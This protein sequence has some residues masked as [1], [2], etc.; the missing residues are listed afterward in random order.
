MPHRLSQET[1]LAIEL[2]AA[3]ENGQ[4]VP[5]FQPQ[6]CTD[7]GR[8][9][10][11]EALARWEHPDNGL[12]SADAFVSLIWEHGLTDRFNEVILYQSLRALQQWTKAGFHVPTVAVNFSASDLANPKIVDK[13]KWELDRFE[14]EPGR[15][16]VEILEN[17]LTSS[18]NHTIS[19]NISALHDLGCRIDLDDFGT[20]HASLAS[21]RRFSVNRIKIDRSFVSRCDLDR[22][23]QNMLAA[24]LTMAEHLNVETLAEG[25]ES[26]GEHAMLAQL[27]C[28]H[29]QG[30]SI[31]R[32][33]PSH[34]CIDWMET[35]RRKQA[36]TPQIGKRAG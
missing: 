36:Q 29:V 15:L 30:F 3:L 23:Q 34:K 12:I 13:V 2:E 25:I 28:N 6:L 14:I 35:H 21:I 1:D 18:D 19:R 26:I 7:T 5:W 33:L 16:A 8:V 32:P 4:I 27:G 24:I 22:E 11:M 20:G 31:S 10:G 9:S 17:V